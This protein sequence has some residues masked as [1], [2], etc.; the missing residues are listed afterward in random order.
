M[1]TR[2]LGPLLDNDRKTGSE[3]VRSLEVFLRNDGS[4][5]RSATVLG[6]HRQTLV[7]RLGQVERLTGLK[8]TSTVAIAAFWTAFEAAH[9]SGVLSTG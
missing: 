8:P 6:V 5:T 7:Y 4:W 1:V 2:V 9:T 3:L